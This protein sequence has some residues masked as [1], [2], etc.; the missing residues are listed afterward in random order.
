M[1]MNG[2]LQGRLEAHGDGGGSYGVG[3]SSER[4]RL[5]GRKK[6]GRSSSGRR[7]ELKSLLP[8]PS[9]PRIGVVRR[10]VEAQPDHCALLPQLQP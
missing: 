9:D 1:G 6:G 10:D 3:A 2:V 7:L 4:L 8:S 5:W